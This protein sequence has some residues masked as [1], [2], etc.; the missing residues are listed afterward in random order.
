M[1]IDVIKTVWWSWC[2]FPWDCQQNA[3]VD[4]VSLGFVMTS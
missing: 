3:N 4:N 2:F 1:I